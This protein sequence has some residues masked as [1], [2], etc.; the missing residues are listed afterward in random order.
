MEITPKSDREL[1]ELLE[2]LL[3]EIV[4]D[5]KVRME[6]LITQPIDVEKN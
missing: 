2:Q 3:A 5:P 1:E 4:A 6:M